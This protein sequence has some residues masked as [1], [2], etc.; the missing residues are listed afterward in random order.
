MRKIISYCCLIA[1]SALGLTS[2]YKD[3][4]NYSY[5]SINQVTFSNFDTINGYTTYFN[6]TFKVT[7]TLVSS[8]NKNADSDYTY[9]WSYRLSSVLSSSADSL[10]STGRNLNKLITLAPGSYILMYKVTDKTTGVTFQTKTTL[11][12]STAVYE[13]YLVLNDVGGKSRLDMLS[14]NKT[15]N[16]FTQY[17]D[18]LQKQGSS[19]PMDGQPN[20]VLSMVYTRSNV[21]KQN[22]GI[23]LAT[24]TST[25]RVNQETFAWDP[26]YNIRYLTVG[27]PPQN[28]TAQ[29]LTGA[30]INTNS[31]TTIYMYATDGNMYLYS[32][33]A[34]FALKYTPL[35]VYTVAGTPFRTTPWVATD[36]TTGVFYDADNR[37]FV[38]SSSPGATTVQQPT[39]NLNYPTG[40]DLVWMD[41]NY[42]PE[43]GQTKTTYAILKDPVTSK[44]YLLRFKI[45]VAQDY[46]QEIT[47]TDIANANL[48]AVSPDFG[49][50]FYSAGGKIYEY[51]LALQQSFL[52]V[53]KG[54]AQISYLSFLHIYDRYGNTN[55]VNWSKQ[56][57]VG[58]YDPAGPAGANGTLERYTV[59]PVNGQITLTS[60][61]TGFGKIVSVAYRARF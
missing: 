31:S 3:L 57:T 9:V 39:S 23:F 1:L 35:N 45:G 27:N 55:Y 40:Y 56:L 13:G 20:Q 43:A 59:Q 14:F 21:V 29:R 42:Y 25:N 61:W 33:N 17:T 41:C 8:L 10:L 24:S 26:T 4:G 32:T 36:G 2:C 12:V 19:V 46:F 30:Y 34:G 11:L 47:G 22:Y 54:S 44:I 6:D 48:F 58:S 52:M 37:N 28:F 5:H 49:Y 53:D 60:G 16:V 15:Q 18:V 38:V 51:D 7:P 50:L